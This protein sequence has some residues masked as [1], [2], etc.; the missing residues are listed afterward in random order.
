MGKIIHGELFFI[1]VA[2]PFMA[3]P[4]MLAMLNLLARS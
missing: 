1:P 3:G 2:V 4:S